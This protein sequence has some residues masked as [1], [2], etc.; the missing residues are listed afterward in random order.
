VFSLRLTGAELTLFWQEAK[1]R[2]INVSELIRQATLREIASA[3]ESGG[4]KEAAVSL[5]RI[6]DQIERAGAEAATYVPSA[7]RPVLAASEEKGPAY[8]AGAETA[9]AKRTAR[10]RKG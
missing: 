6:A 9:A 3:S 8:E 1:R 10:R 2:G 4:L 7:R 5:R